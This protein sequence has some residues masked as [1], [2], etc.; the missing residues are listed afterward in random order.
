MSEPGILINQKRIIK[1]GIT[2]N[3]YW[4]YKIIKKRKR[5][6]GRPRGSI[7]NPIHITEW[8]QTFVELYLEQKTKPRKNR[9]N[10]TECYRIA[11]QNY[12]AKDTSAQV[13]ASNLLTK[14]KIKK[15]IQDRRKAAAKKVDLGV[16]KVLKGLLRIAEFDPRKLLDK[17][18]HPLP[19]HKL[20]D[21][22][23]LAI[24]S[25][26]F[27]RVV[28]RTPSGRRKIKYIPKKVK[29]ESRK[30]AWELLGTH[31][32]MFTGGGNE[33]TPQDFVNDVRKFADAVQSAVPGGQI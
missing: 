5:P 8:E 27:E 22:T 31:L 11:F 3:G 28:T 15:Y 20:D 23:A 16:T 14:P 18:G 13:M 25:L 2:R 19:L 4:P 21:E 17:K 10:Q 24:S 7:K 9:L 12:K 33:N 30:P 26:E 32:N 6:A 1:N 29:H